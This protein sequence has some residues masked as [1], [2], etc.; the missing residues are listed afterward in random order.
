MQPGILEQDMAARP[1]KMLVG[2]VPQWNSERK[3]M[4]LF[5]VNFF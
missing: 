4:P 2:W 5:E 1:V 3:R